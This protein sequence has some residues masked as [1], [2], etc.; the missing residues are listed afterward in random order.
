[1]AF[2]WGI[3]AVRGMMLGRFGCLAILV[4]VDKGCHKLHIY[5]EGR[6]EIVL[7]Y[8]MRLFSVHTLKIR[9]TQRYSQR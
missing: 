8:I 7:S 4:F 9:R 3:I 6:C 2:S 1:M 5:V